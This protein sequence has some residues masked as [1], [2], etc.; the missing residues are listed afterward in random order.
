[1]FVARL[2]EEGKADVLVCSSLR[3]FVNDKNFSHVPNECLCKARLNREKSKEQDAEPSRLNLTSI[4]F[5]LRLFVS[6][7]YAQRE[8][9]CTLRLNNKVHRIVL[10]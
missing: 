7:P 3:L 5:N 9:I 4:S 6:L 1:M 8:T 2:P 10:N